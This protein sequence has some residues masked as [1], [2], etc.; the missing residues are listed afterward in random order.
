MD[1]EALQ[2]GR[3]AMPVPGGSSE[4]LQ[5]TGESGNPC[6]L[7]ILRVEIVATPAPGTHTQPLCE[8]SEMSPTPHIPFL[9]ISE[10]WEYPPGVEKR[11]SSAED[12]KTDP[13]TA[14]GMASTGIVD[15]EITSSVIRVFLVS[16]VCSLIALLLL[17]VAPAWAKDIKK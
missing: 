11:F 12:T 3:Q 5:P 10:L 8:C 14:E 7:A 2:G 6:P 15:A 16:V 1:K 9:G 17:K 13:N 4:A